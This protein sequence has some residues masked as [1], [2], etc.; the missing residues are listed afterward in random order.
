MDSR[1]EE[2]E[3][4]RVR[5]GWVQGEVLLKRDRAGGEGCGERETLWTGTELLLGVHTGSL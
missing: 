1:R 4:G 2:E 3:C 5:E